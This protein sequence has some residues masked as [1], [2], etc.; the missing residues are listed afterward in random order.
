MKAT[1]AARLGLS[2]LVGASVFL[3][4][5]GSAPPLEKTFENKNP[6]TLQG[7]KELIK[8]TVDHAVTK[9]PFWSQQSESDQIE[10]KKFL[11][12]TFKDWALGEKNIAW[13]RVIQ[14][15]STLP[16]KNSGIRVLFCEKDGHA[17]SFYFGY[18]QKNTQRYSHIVP[19]LHAQPNQN[20]GLCDGDKPNTPTRKLDSGLH[21]Y[22]NLPNRSNQVVAIH[23][24]SR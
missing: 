8:T 14:K 2:L 19:P 6:L 18:P 20:N 21:L 22:S 16:Q 1:I 3:K 13:T 17:S 12:Q 5:C 10:E 11:N 4:G 9:D 24:N 7:T 23:T 15:K